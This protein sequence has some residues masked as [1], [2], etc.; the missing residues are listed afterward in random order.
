VRG[1]RGSRRRSRR[2]R[3]ACARARSPRP[4]R[5]SVP[6]PKSANTSRNMVVL[7]VA[8]GV[9]ASLPIVSYWEKIDPVGTV[10]GV[11][12]TPGLLPAVVVLITAVGI[13]GSVGPAM[14]GLKVEPMEALRPE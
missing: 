7:G 11:P 13:A 2:T 6:G 14:R 8:L 12:D 4:D 9:V 1:W 10:L 5:H 3:P